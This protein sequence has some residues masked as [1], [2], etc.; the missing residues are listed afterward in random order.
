MLRATNESN[1]DQF[2]TTKKSIR[3]RANEI[4]GLD[5]EIGL[6]LESSKET[7]QGTGN[8]FQK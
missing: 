4:C 1:R 3:R 6:I 7:E 8:K 5:H 2:R